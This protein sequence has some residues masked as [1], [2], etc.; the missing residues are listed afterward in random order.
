MQDT[1]KDAMPSPAQPASPTNDDR[2][3]AVERKLDRIL[4]A[5]DRLAGVPTSVGPT[6]VRDPFKTE[7]VQYLPTAVEPLPEP[8]RPEDPR[9][10]RVL[11]EPASP[12]SRV[13]SISQRLKAVEE[14]LESTKDRLARLEARLTGLEKHVGVNFTD[15]R[16][17]TPETR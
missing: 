6:M 15:T 10:A 8:S 17:S 7:A 16:P 1:R 4:N 3:D 12:P 9:N 11:V 13:A 2:T 5:L 14:V